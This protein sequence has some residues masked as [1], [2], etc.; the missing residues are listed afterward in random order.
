MPAA[1]Q[2]YSS[3]EINLDPMP[4][5]DV[6]VPSEVLGIQFP[7]SSDVSSKICLHAALNTVTL[8]DNLPHPNPANETARNPPYRSQTAHVELPR[9]MPTLVCCAM[10]SGYALLMLCLKA[11]GFQSSSG[12]SLVSVNASSLAGFRSDLQQSLRLVVKLISNYA[13][14]FE[15]LQGIRGKTFPHSLLGVLPTCA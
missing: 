2:L 4:T 7:F 5:P 11:R 1:R 13:L 10:Q 6:S 9:T 12:D 3:S 8:L 15:A 14:A